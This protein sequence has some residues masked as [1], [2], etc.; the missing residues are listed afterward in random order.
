MKLLEAWKDCKNYD[1]RLTRSDPQ[2]SQL[3]SSDYTPTTNCET[4]LKGVWGIRE[5]ANEE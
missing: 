2:A 5:A 3:I 1:S 4:N